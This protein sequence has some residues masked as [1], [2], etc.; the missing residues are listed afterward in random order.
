[1]DKNDLK[2]LWHDAYV[3]NKENIYDKVNIQKSL[4]MNHSK[5]ISK[6]LSDVKLKIL[7]YLS[8]LMIF[9]GL[10][11]Y[12]LGYLGLS[13]SMNSIIPLA[14]VGIFLAIKTTSEIHRFKILTRTADNMTVKESLLLFRKKLDRIKIADFLTYLVFF[15]LLAI[16]IIINYLTD[17]SGIK[18]LSWSNEILPVPL[19][20]ILILMLL[21]F[22]WF[23]KYQHN[24]RYKN[25]YTNLNESASILNDEM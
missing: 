13:L 22:P 7:L 1:M 11:I 10:M 18:N 15:Y 9:I 12:A 4:S 6:V 3:L 19:L 17:I 20:G 24:Q 2:K 8:V 21:F 16:L 25:L 14:L 23:I 5:S